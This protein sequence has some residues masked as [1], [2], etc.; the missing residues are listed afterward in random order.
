MIKWLIIILLAVPRIIYSE[1]VLLIMNANKEKYP[2]EKRYNVVRNTCLW[3]CK[4]TRT[5]FNIINEDVIN[6]YSEKGRLFVSY[7]FLL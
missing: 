1:I 2:L 5:R 7:Y 3:V 6:N 4:L